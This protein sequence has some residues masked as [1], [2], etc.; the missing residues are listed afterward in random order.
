MCA[1][2]PSGKSRNTLARRRHHNVKCE[3]LRTECW[4]VCPRAE[5]IAQII[6]G[7]EALGSRGAVSLALLSGPGIRRRNLQNPRKPKF[8][9]PHGAIV[10]P[11]V[12][13][14]DLSERRAL[15]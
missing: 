2:L 8:T 5:E 12:V 6:G 10:T 3:H 1:D 7:Q 15:E 4:C 13:R 11:G 14:P 9:A